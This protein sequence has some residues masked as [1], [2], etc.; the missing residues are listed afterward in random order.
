MRI[1]LLRYAEVS[2]KLPRVYIGMGSNLGCREDNLSRAVENLLKVPGVHPAC[3]SSVYETDPEGYANQPCF[4]NLV[5]G[6]DVDLSPGDLLAACQSIEERLG[7]IR[8]AGMRWGPRT[9]DLDIL[10]Y[11]DLAFST[12]D[13]VV[14]H[15]L[16]HLRR[17]VLVPLLEVAPEVVVPGKGPARELLSRLDPAGKEKVRKWGRLKRLENRR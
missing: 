4:L 6:M 7:R 9:I 14:P 3:L 13:L 10:L 8:G 5:I 16:M 15:P 12:P 2:G 17:F 11:G 1:F